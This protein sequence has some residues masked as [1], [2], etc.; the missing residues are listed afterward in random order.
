MLNL[1]VGALRMSFPSRI[2]QRSWLLLPI[3]AAVFLGWTN[4]IG[5]RRVQSVS[6]LAGHTE[7]RSLE[8]A[9]SSTGYI[10]GQRELISP[11]R[12]EASFE[13]IAQTQQMVTNHEWRV[14]HVDYDNAPFG[15]TVET[16]SPYRWWLRSLATLDRAISGRPIGLSVER[17]ALL[18]NPLLHGLMWGLGAVFVTWRFGSFA[19]AVFAVGLATLFPWAGGFVPGMP[20]A[21]GL[22]RILGLVTVLSLLAGCRVGVGRAVWFAASGVVGGLGLWVDVSTEMPILGGLCLGGL[23]AGWIARSNDGL[24]GEW[25]DA[26]RVW[27]VAGAATTGLTYLIEY[28]PAHL[29]SWN[30]EQIHPIYGIAW[31]G[32]GE[33]L[34]RWPAASKTRSLS[35]KWSDGCQVLSAVAA[36]AL[37]PIVMKLTASRGFL[38]LD[39]TSVRLSSQPGAI[40]ALSFW[41]WLSRDGLTPTVIATVW[42]LL[43]I[44][45]AVWWV[46][47]TAK[48]Q[49]RLGLALALGPVII[50]LIF[51]LERL[52]AWS[53]CDG[54]LLSMLVLAASVDEAHLAVR[55]RWFWMAGLAIMATPGVWQLWP[56]KAAGGEVTLTRSEADELVERDLAQRLAQ[57]SGGERAVVFAPPHE[58]ASL[59][60]YGGL[61]GIGTF[62]AENRAGFGATLSI[63][64]ADSME[65]AQ[66][67]LQ[68]RDVRYIVVPSWDPFF[69]EFAR[70]Y[71]V[72]QF[73]GRTSR[74]IREL[75]VWHLPLWLR[76]VFYGLPAIHGY[77]G[78]SVQIFEVVDPQSP[79]VAA[80]RLAE[81]LSDMGQLDEAG[82]LAETL[83]RFPADVGAL[84]ARAHV[85][86]AQADVGGA[87]QIIEALLPRLLS[88]ADRVLPWDRRVSLAVALAQAGQLEQASRQVRRCMAE[89]NAQKLRELSTGSLYQL[90][91]LSSAVGANFS[92]PLLRGLALE[93][94][95]AELRTKL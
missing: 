27:A 76:P 68:A 9:K 92:D 53:L 15:R 13:E 94:L 93:L 46:A 73:S 59:C 66:G 58:T 86:N 50:T 1:V 35:W 64:G 51:A 75:R 61:R 87:Q 80:S 44:L 31:L 23:M 12:S 38:R 2:I 78:R 17:A 21:Q 28:A 81:Y 24:G 41:S 83:R 8:D 3:F 82:K 90:L 20:E 6:G 52:S 88:G 47:R 54:A 45:P 26:W 14:R 7:Q 10:R 5:I 29:F 37:I 30:L 39:L 18:G 57:R 67:Q 42:P 71:L 36:L 91:V 33:L 19:G 84:V 85:L 43:L 74:L 63:T 48:P 70:R 79:A 34:A 55:R 40:S 89:V 11:E 32:A 77:E 62:S 60:Y 69:D 22:S 4:L 95:P 72:A 25:R 49:A 65:E 56:A 16:S